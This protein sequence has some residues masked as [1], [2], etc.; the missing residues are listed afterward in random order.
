MFCGEIGFKDFFYFC[1]LNSPSII[2]RNFFHPQTSK[3]EFCIQESIDDSF[4]ILSSNL[5]HSN[6]HFYSPSKERTIFFG[7]E[8]AFAQV[9]LNLINNAKDAIVS[10]NI[11]D[12]VVEIDVIENQEEIKII[13]QDNAGGIKIAEIEKIFEPYFTTKHKSVGTGIGLYMVKQI[14]ENQME[15]KIFVKNAFWISKITKQEYF[16]A[17]FEITLSKAKTQGE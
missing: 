14:V 7:Y 13:A 8:N 3:E 5:K 10:E 17:I 15:G 9:V 16:G 11:E 6:I 1:N 12:G 2:F 4:C